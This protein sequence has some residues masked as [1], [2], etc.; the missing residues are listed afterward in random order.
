MK[1]AMLNNFLKQLSTA[2]ILINLALM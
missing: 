1:L 2:R